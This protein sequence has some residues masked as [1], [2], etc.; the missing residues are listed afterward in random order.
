MKRLISFPSLKARFSCGGVD[1][2]WTDAEHEEAAAAGEAPANGTRKIP[3]QNKTGIGKAGVEFIDE[4]GG[5][6]G[7][8]LRKPQRSKQ[9]K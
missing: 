5:G 2:V 6:P 8:R 4:N 3:D 1:Q 7:V 9:S